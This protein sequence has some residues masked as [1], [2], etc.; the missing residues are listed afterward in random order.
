MYALNLCELRE[1]RRYS[2]LVSLIVIPKRPDSLSLAGR[3]F[4]FVKPLLH[5]F[6]F[7]L[8]GRALFP[9][10][11]KPRNAC[12]VES[13]AV[14]DYGARLHVL[15]E[16]DEGPMRYGGRASPVMPIRADDDDALLDINLNASRVDCHRR[17]RRPAARGLQFSFDFQLYGTPSG[18][19]VAND[20]T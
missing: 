3:Q 5:G 7:L 17:G 11:C 16:L 19:D 6:D 14:E 13:I 4:D 20:Y 15:A 2:P 12:P 9:A 8:D 1:S 18:E 10:R